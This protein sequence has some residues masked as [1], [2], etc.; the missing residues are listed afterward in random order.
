MLKPPAALRESRVKDERANAVTMSFQTQKEFKTMAKRL[1]QF[2]SVA[3]ILALSFIGA[4]AQYSS[5][6]INEREARDIVRRI[7]DR[8]E[9]LR[10]RIRNESSNDNNNI[11][12]VFGRKNKLENLVEDFQTKTYNL[13][14][15]L[16]QRRATSSDAQAVINKA[17]NIS[18]YLSKNSVSN[19]IRDDW[20]RVRSEVDK[21]A[22]AFY[23]NDNYGGDYDKYPQY[24][25]NDYPRENGNRSDFLIPD[26]TQIVATLNTDL[27]TKNIQDGERFT[28][29][30]E[31]PR[32]YRGAIIEGYVS[33]VN[34]SGRVKGRSEMTLNFQRIRHYGNTYRFAGTVEAIQTANGEKVNTDEGSVRESDSRGKTTAKRAAI[35]A[36]VGAI[37][38]AI[39]GGGKGAAIGAAIGAGAGA[40]SV[41]I[42]GP[43]D[44]EIMSGSEVT[45]RASAPRNGYRQ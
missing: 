2:V 18:A 41:L 29:T 35:G 40:G 3:F 36:G 43:D 4:S 9:R 7:Q 45:V 39:A 37:I 30:V 14:E 42:Q 22:R 1:N 44:L 13:S 6:R 24:P 19:R 21:L 5:Y 12:G 10:E 16:D 25:Q 33:N 11:F 28:M 27:N 31:S 38:G 26:G 15:R 34:R 20:S 32:A 8:T 23:L 17:E